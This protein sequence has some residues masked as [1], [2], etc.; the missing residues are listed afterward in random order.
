MFCV[1]DGVQESCVVG[2]MSGWLP[3]SHLNWTLG[4]TVAFMSAGSA[5]FLACAN[6]Y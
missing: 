4:H 3:W 6:S 1:D 5:H 2:N